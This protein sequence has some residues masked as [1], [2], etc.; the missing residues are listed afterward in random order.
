[1]SVEGFL[2]IGAVVLLAPESSTNIFTI[3][4]MQELD[5]WAV[6]SD[7]Y[8]IFH[9]FGHIFQSYYFE[10]VPEIGVPLIFLDDDISFK[11]HWRF[12]NLWFAHENTS[13][14]GY[15]LSLCSLLSFCKS[16]FLAQKDQKGANTWDIEG[17]TDSNRSN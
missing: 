5:T 4:D 7:I 16:H 3:L 14:L 1:M 10:L 11:A 6:F 8:N 15:T 12:Q 9:F 13:T 17:K 2:F